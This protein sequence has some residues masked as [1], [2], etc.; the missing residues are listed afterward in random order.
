MTKLY[1]KTKSWTLPAIALIAIVT[2]LTVT[3]LKQINN[4]IPYKYYSYANQPDSS[5]Q[6]DTLKCYRQIEKIQNTLSYLNFDNY[7][8]SGNA[9]EDFK[10]LNLCI[11]NLSVPVLKDSKKELFQEIEYGIFLTEKNNINDINADSLQKDIRHFLFVTG[12]TLIYYS[13][14]RVGFWF[15]FLVYFSQNTLFIF[16]TI[17]ML[18]SVFTFV[19]NRNLYS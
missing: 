11:N 12:L 19:T 6:E 2:G 13:E 4:T 16:I 1:N 5:S 8:A 10:Y 15:N 9:G 14:F 18:V 17:F 3:T 7:I